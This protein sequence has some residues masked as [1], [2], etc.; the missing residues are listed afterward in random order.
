MITRVEWFEL[1]GR[2]AEAEVTASAD[3]FT[4]TLS[5][6]ASPTGSGTRRPL[7]IVL[8]VRTPVRLSGLGR[9]WAFWSMSRT[10]SP[11]DRDM[12]FPIRWLARG[13]CDVGKPS[14]ARTEVLLRCRRLVNDLLE[15]ATAA[16]DAVAR[17]VA[18]RFRPSVRFRVYGQVIA[19]GTGRIGQLAGAS[20][21]SLLFALALQSE[22]APD[23]RAAGHRL[24]SDAV[25]GRNL[26]GALDQAVEAWASAAETAERLRLARWRDA[27]Q[28]LDVAGLGR[29][30]LLGQQRLLVRRAGR[31]VNPFLLLL[32]PP[33][34][35]APEDIPAAPRANARWY[36]MMK[37]PALLGGAAPGDSDRR[38][39]GLSA[40]LSR[41]GLQLTGDDLHVHPAILP[42]RLLDFLHAVEGAPPARASSLSRLLEKSLGW[43]GGVAGDRDADNRP[44]PAAPLA[45]WSSP[46]V[47]VGA[48]R[49]AGALA[50]EG[51]DMHNCVASLTDRARAGLSFFFSAV[52]ADRHLT[53]E[54][55]PGADGRLDIVEL[56]GR[57]NRPATGAERAALLPWLTEM[58]R[59]ATA[60][61]S[62]DHEVGAPAID[63]AS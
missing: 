32:P 59:R 16:S 31:L 34:A 47:E 27:W 54:V 58:N 37:H 24:L 48:L 33:L 52:V 9:R 3:G 36:A 39:A 22:Q 25:A 21:G 11:V 17:D 7:R 35:F 4:L 61:E 12:S 19:D 29:E 41:T 6:V 23:L 56:A 14:R 46:S 49:D 15:H 18:M 43:H 62:V 42:G 51:A 53:V 26:D 13:I 60:G 5:S 50:V 10:L 2:A 40:L 20:P 45:Q 55:R 63:H 44:F 57:A 8:R 28:R 38:A 1:D 30:R